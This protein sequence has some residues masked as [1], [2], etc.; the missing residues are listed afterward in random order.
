MMR[1]TWRLGKEQVEQSELLTRAERLDRS[2]P[3]AVAYLAMAQ[4]RVGGTDEARQ[5]L[6]RL[7]QLLQQDRWKNDADYHAFLRE[8]KA[9]T[10]FP[11]PEQNPLF[12]TP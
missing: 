1:T 3:I 9:L 5:L 8:A 11:S 6:E 7:R 4:H 2:H 10:N 12:E